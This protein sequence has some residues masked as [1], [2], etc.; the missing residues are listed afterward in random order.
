MIIK[1]R[2]ERITRIRIKINNNRIEMKVEIKYKMEV[3]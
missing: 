2:K 3:K 1:L